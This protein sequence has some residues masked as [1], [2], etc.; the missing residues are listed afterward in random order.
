MSNQV[1]PAERLLDLVIALTHT[2]HRMTRSEIRRGVNGYAQAPSD[3]A[4]ERMFERDKVTLRELGIPLVTLVDDAHGDDVGYRIDLDDYAMPEIELTPE[5]IGVLSVAAAMWQ[6]AEQDARAR[7]GLTKLRALAPSVSDELAGHVL[8]MPIAQ[9]QVEPL[10]QAA[11]ARG[12]VQ[13]PDRTART[14]QVEQREVEPWR[15]LVRDGAWYLQGWDRLRG[16]ERLFRLSRIT[17]EV[18]DVTGDGERAAVGPA[19]TPVAGEE[20]ARLRV[21]PERAGALRLRATSVRSDGEGDV[22]TMPL[23]DVEQLAALVAGDTDAVMVL[24]PA[25]LRD[26]VV[27]RLAAVAALAGGEH[28]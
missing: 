25:E 21:R 10:L 8:R 7:R 12:V 28:A 1:T 18:R 11:T 6:G 17:G 5:E 27:A 2:T 13:F 20:M 14:G 4:F 19:P 26:A 22:L 3:D 9:P 23:G 15:L 16:A 24:S